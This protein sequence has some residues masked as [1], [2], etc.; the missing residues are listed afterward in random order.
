MYR[1]GNGYGFDT[2]MDHSRSNSVGLI[3]YDGMK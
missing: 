1:W 3:V 2:S